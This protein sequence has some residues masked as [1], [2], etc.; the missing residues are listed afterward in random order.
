LIDEI[1]VTSVN[2][3]GTVAGGGATFSKSARSMM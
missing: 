3:A 1:V 2:P